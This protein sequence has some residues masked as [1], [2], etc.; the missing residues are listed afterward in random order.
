MADSREPIEACIRA[1]CDEGD[2][3]AAT[4]ISVQAYGPEILGFLVAR[5]RDE[6]RGSEVFSLFC[7]DLWRGLPGFQWRCTARV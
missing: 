4:T 5:L 1:A 7:S 3:D 2:Y 6:S